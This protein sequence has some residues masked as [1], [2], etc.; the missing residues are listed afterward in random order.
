MILK[1]LNVKLNKFTDPEICDIITRIQVKCELSE[2]LRDKKIKDIKICILQDGSQKSMLC[3][4]K[5]EDE[6]IALLSNNEEG[7]Y[8]SNIILNNQGFSDLTLVVFNR[9][10]LEIVK[11]YFNDKP[12][13]VVIG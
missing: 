2:F 7:Y 1:V 10:A 5:Y 6:V 11:G 12:Y 3:I 9:R 13:K 4:A 8:I